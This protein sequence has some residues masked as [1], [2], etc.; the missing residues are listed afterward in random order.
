M[1]ET[2]NTATNW[3]SVGQADEFTSDQHACVTAG[4]KQ[5]VVFNVEGTFHVISNTCP[6][7][8]LPLGDGERRGMVI[9]CPYHGYTYHIKTGRNIDW[10][11]DEMPVR[12][13]RS[14]VVDG[15]LEIEMEAPVNPRNSEPQRGPAPQ[16]KPEDEGPE[17]NPDP[18][19][20]DSEEP[21]CPTGYPNEENAPPQQPSTD[22]PTPN[23]PP[24]RKAN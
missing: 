1:L 8:G 20:T 4:D 12:T 24:T 2:S 15:R 11:E 10:P 16:D 13:Y 5:V 6:H 22:K 21:E 14:R 9:T 7:A 17:C 23:P 19:Q 18:E 3:V